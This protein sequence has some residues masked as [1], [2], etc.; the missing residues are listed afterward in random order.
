MPVLA[1]QLRQEPPSTVGTVLP[2]D[3]EL[4]EHP[5]H[6]SDIS[7]G[8]LQLSVRIQEV[9]MEHNGRASCVKRPYGCNFPLHLPMCSSPWGN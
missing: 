7:P 4:P 6:P 1:A 9:F 2:A 5:H 3:P 8:S